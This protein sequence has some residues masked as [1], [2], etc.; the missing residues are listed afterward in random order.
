VQDAAYGTLLRSRRRQLHARIAAA[1]EDRFPEIVKA[2]QALL[3]HH[4]AEAGLPE[5]AVDYW[6]A[7]GRQAR[8]RATGAEALTL[9]RRGLAL[10]PALP[11]GDRRREAEFDLQIALGQALI[12]TRGFAAP[13]VGE[14]YG[15]ARQLSATLNRPRAL[16]SALYGQFLFRWGGGDFRQACQLADEMGGLGED[17]GNLPARVMGCN[18]SAMG[19]F[20]L[21][22][23]V[24]A[25]T[26]VEKGL[27][28]YDP[29]YRPDY[30]E[31]LP[32]D[33]RVLLLDVS[34]VPLVCLGHLDQGMARREAAM[35]E[36]RRLS[37]APTLADALAWA[38]WTGWCL[39]LDPKAL[40]QSADEGLALAA[41]RGHE[42]FRLVGLVGR[43]WCLTALGR[44]VEGIPLLTAGLTL[45]RELRV[46]AWKPTALTMAGDACRMAGEFQAALDH[47]AEARRLAEE[48]DARWNQAETLRL[49]G[50]ALRAMGD[51]IGAEASY[52]EA[53]AIAQRQRAKFWELRAATSL[54]RLWR[55]QGRQSEAHDL[56]S[57]VYGWFTAG[58][59]TPVLQEARALL[60]DLAA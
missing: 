49:R 33:M 23:F 55:H 31:L 27:A 39:G 7:A 30:A 32:V 5:K 1:L 53:I 26:D 51:S 4:C 48:T 3:A 22:E 43:G 42:Q 56:L 24:A 21:G 16:L 15:R 45:W 34:I 10:V 19:C 8:V 14:V 57:S 28:L 58:F 59:G 29:A 20:Q 60:E 12:M 2:Q 25:R 11:D 41:E 9:L 35:T 50:E 40:L 17:S 6:L 54:A 46:T 37:H 47:L 13:E 44:A 38:I 52:H 36:A 18:C